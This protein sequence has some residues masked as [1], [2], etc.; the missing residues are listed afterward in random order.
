MQLGK[1]GGKIYS[2]RLPGK[3]LFGAGVSERVCS[4]AKA[5]GGSKVLL[6][7]DQNLRA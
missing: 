5:L 3:I 2:F 4:E 7:T 1:S 6:V